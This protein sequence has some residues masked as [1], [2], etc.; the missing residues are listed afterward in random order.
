MRPE[1]REA[2]IY[3]SWEREVQAGIADL[4]IPQEVRGALGF[5]SMKKVIDWLSSPPTWF[6]PL[7]EGDPI[8]GRD[9]FLRQTFARAIEGLNRRFGGDTDAWRYGD[10]R[11]K[12]VLLHHPLSRAVDEKTRELLEVGPASRGGDGYTVGQTGFG[13]NQTSGASFRIIT[14]AGDWDAAVFM[15]TPGQG[16]N[17]EDPMYRN[18]FDGWVKDRFFP[19]YYS[20]D[21]VEAAL[22][23]RLEL[24][25][26]TR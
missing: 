12:H 19:L 23:E 25:P 7:G 2:A 10:P 18:L 16:G 1:S 15:N 11:F 21:R 6:A 20:R 14:E 9:A 22:A 5:V 24:D 4:A 8:A 26:G 17:P 3:V 13:D